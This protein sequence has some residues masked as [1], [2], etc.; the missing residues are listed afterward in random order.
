[1]TNK[2][3]FVFDTNTLV[4]ALLF[5]E[6]VPRKAFDRAMESGVILISLDVVAELN[7]VLSRKKFNKYVT[8]EERIEFLILL[9]HETVFV[10]VKENIAECR[11]QRDDK[12]LEL[13][14]CGNSQYIISG[15]A[16]LLVLHPFRNI[17]IV[18]PRDFLELI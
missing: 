10:E 16:D 7:D 5:K 11:D 9:L 17:S 3:R 2:P 1:M 8:E 4:S 12:F 14:V 15:D 6:S 13:A 18:T